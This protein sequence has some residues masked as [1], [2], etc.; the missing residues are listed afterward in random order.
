MARS[1]SFLASFSRR[2]SGGEGVRELVTQHEREGGGQV[3]VDREGVSG[4]EAEGRG[5][6]EDM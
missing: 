6:T 5:E 2:E 4:M 1:E 3:M